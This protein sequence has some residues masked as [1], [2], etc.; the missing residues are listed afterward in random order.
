MK[1]QVDDNAFSNLSRN[2]TFSAGDGGNVSSPTNSIGPNFATGDINN[3]SPNNVGPNGMNGNDISSGSI[4][5]QHGS[6]SSSA[7]MWLHRFH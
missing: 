3:N 6:S 1:R 2:M 4:F 7:H 5:T